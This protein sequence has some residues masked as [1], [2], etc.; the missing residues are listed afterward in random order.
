MLLTTSGR[1][2]YIQINQIGFKTLYW[3][4]PL[5]TLF[6]PF[7]EGFVYIVTHCQHP[8]RKSRFHDKSHN[9]KLNVDIF[10]MLSKALADLVCLL[11]N[12]RVN[13]FSVMLGRSHRFLGITSTC[14]GGGGGVN[15]KNFGRVKI[16]TCSM[17]H[18]FQHPQSTVTNPP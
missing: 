10:A 9:T 13:N 1:S 18:N 8:V 5:K 6:F 2:F 17:N 14:W 16:D 4:I 12:F 3:G 7:L 15:M 11:L